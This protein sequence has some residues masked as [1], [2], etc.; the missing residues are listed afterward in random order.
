M[1]IK[2]NKHKNSLTSWRQQQL[3]DNKKN[4]AFDVNNNFDGPREAH[5]VT[6]KH[7]VRCSMDNA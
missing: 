2:L 4:K 7:Q 3:I 5:D 6:A 1:R